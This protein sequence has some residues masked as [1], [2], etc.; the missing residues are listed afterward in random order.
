MEI[1]GHLREELLLKKLSS[2]HR[3][4]ITVRLWDLW[5][6]YKYEERSYP[7]DIRNRKNSLSMTA[8]SAIYLN[9]SLNRSARASDFDKY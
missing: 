5:N 4:E 3:N 7:S 2:G 8:T 1:V 9:E 6:L